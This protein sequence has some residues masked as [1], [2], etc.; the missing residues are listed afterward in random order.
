M[1]PKRNRRSLRRWSAAIVVIGAVMVAWIVHTDA[2]RSINEAV[3]LL[4]KRRDIPAEVMPQ[5]PPTSGTRLGYVL[6]GAGS[7]PCFRLLKEPQTTY[8][9]NSLVIKYASASDFVAEFA[10]SQPAKGEAKTDGEAVLELKNTFIREGTGTYD[11]AAACGVDE[12]NRAITWE[13]GAGRLVL[14]TADKS[15][16]DGLVNA[17]HD[18][19]GEIEWHASGANQ[20]EAENVI[21][22]VNTT[23]L[24][25]TKSEAVSTEVEDVPQPGMQIKLP[26]NAPDDIAL[27]MVVFDRRH[28]L[29]VDVSGPRPFVSSCLDPAIERRLNVPINGVC[30]I[31]MDNASIDIRTQQTNDNRFMFVTTYF[32]TREMRTK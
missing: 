2:P 17:E 3:L 18:T 26:R 30:V 19:K 1:A 8:S 9:L 31:A 5:V 6:N 23:I 11:E 4:R 27:A 10:H 12:D 21:L 7:L 29:P 14:T 25:T 28:P 15:I 13:W 16:T 22:A 32:V 24:H 20:V